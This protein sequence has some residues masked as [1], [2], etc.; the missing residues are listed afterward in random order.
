MASKIA[1][2]AADIVKGA[3]FA[4]KRDIEISKARAKRDWQ[5][6]FRLSLDQKT[7]FDVRERSRPR[8]ADVCTM[9]SD[10]CSIKITEESL[11]KRS[12][13]AEK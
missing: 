13:E 10:Y 7:P 6:Q 4:L 5:K 8:K 9:C 1:A 2:H 11:K 3:P 12:R